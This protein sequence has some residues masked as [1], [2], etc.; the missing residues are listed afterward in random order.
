MPRLVFD[1]G[2]GVICYELDGEFY[3]YGLTNSGDPRVCPSE[4]MARE[5]AASAF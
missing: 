4:G 2:K 3:V 5:I 1:H